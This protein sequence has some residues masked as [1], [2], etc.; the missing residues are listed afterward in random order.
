MR[1]QMELAA[2]RNVVLGVTSLDDVRFTIDGDVSA[3]DDTA[4]E[5]GYIDDAEAAVGLLGPGNFGSQCPSQSTF[6]ENGSGVRGVSPDVVLN[7]DG[8]AGAKTPEPN[9]TDSGIGEKTNL[10]EISGSDPLLNS[11]IDYG[12]LR[13][14]DILDSIDGDCGELHELDSEEVINGPGTPRRQDSYTADNL[15]FLEQLRDAKETDILDDSDDDLLAF[16][17]PGEKMSR[18][19]GV[20]SQ[21]DQAQ[22][23]P[24][25]PNTSS[26]TV[27]DSKR[28]SVKSSIKKS[29]KVKKDK[30]KTSKK[31]KTST[32]DDVRLQKQPEE[33]KHEVDVSDVNGR[34]TG[35]R[36]NEPNCRDSSKTDPPPRGG[37]VATDQISPTKIVLTESEQTHRPSIDRR[38]SIESEPII[39]KHSLKIK[40]RSSSSKLT[41][42]NTM[43]LPPHR[44][45]STLRQ[46]REP[47]PSSD[48]T[49]RSDESFVTAQTDP[50]SA[51]YQTLGVS[52]HSFPLDDITSTMTPPTK[53]MSGCRNTSSVVAF[54][55]EV[56]NRGSRCSY[57]VTSAKME[58]MA[59]ADEAFDLDIDDSE[60][61][62]TVPI[63]VCLLIIATY[64]IGG[65]IL[66]TLWEDWDPL[67]GSYFCFITLSTIGFGDIVPGT[68]MKEWSSQEKLV[69]CSLWL[70][71]GL[72]L[73][74]MCFN[75]MQEEVKGKCKWIG[76]KVGL[77]TNDNDG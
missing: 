63:C 34:Q 14:T 26:A 37:A 17:L 43:K 23:P 20:G 77:L 27:V 76:K 4:G 50:D 58:T 53:L 45:C 75:L 70:A 25:A 30:T 48:E 59:M 21:G 61:K 42:N 1:K 16:H 57:D 8:V 35:D 49:R 68:D 2:Q 73:L 13:E 18:D 39:K 65:S 40:P 15:C 67:T 5:S 6:A 62:V 22:S 46:Q 7:A 56:V 29:K 66:F 38:R 44:K 28:K 32:R 52:V 51:S 74:A 31:H 60:E 41:R 24:K 71:F 3:N 11:Q 69:L 19:D 54:Q 72:S 33:H 36:S 55:P 10:D 9:G 64:I 12:A 47:S